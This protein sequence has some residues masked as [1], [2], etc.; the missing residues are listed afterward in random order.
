MGSV[1]NGIKALIF[2]GVPAALVGGLILDKFLGVEQFHENYSQYDIHRIYDF[3]G[4]VA[5]VECA[6]PTWLGS[7]MITSVPFNFYIHGEQLSMPISCRWEI[8]SEWVLATFVLGITFAFWV[9]R[10]LTKNS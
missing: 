4:K 2:G 5:D 1:V 8:S 9:Y 3:Y 7:D 6:K 10:Y